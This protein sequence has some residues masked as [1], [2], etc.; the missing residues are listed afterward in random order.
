MA[1]HKSSATKGRRRVKFTL[2]APGASD[3]ALVGEFNSWD[4][5]AG[6]MKRGE[7][8]CWEKTVMLSPGHYQYKYLVDG[9]WWN[10]PL[11]Q[12]DCVNCYGT[13]NNILHVEQR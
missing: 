4:P 2:Q 3:V 10:D 6:P 5:A 9:E 11:G 7:T 13:T 12:V 8:G 1:A